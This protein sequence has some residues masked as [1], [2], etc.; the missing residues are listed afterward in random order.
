MAAAEPTQGRGDRCWAWR[1]TARPEWSS[2]GESM[3][4]RL[5]KFSLCNR[6][7]LGTLAKL[8]AVNHNDALGE[9]VDLRR[10]DRWN[11]PALAQ[12]L[13]IDEGV[14]RDGFCTATRNGGFAM[15]SSQLRHCPDCLLAGF[16]AAWF[17]WPF[18]EYCPIRGCGQNLG[19]LGG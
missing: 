13:G 14:V 3:W 5:S 11:E 8:F 10:A 17:Q 15:A 2:V 12:I 6:L 9:G 16:H 4:M 19:L 7:A 1:Y 18:I